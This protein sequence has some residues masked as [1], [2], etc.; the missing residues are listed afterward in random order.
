MRR[1]W[2][3][4]DGRQMP[5]PPRRPDVA[6]PGRSRGVGRVELV[7]TG[8]S[9]GKAISMLGRLI[10]AARILDA[11]PAA[12]RRAASMGTSMTTAVTSVATAAT[13]VA[14]AATR[15]PAVGA[16]MA[17]AVAPDLLD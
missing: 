1:A 9:T 5:L 3:G 13:C 8:V 2:P 7:W 15:V 12:V 14:A 6:R 10:D 16:T 17:L 4:R 11:G